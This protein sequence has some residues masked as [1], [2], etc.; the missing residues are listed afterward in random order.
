MVN[1][2]VDFV[3]FGTPKFGDNVMKFGPPA[4]QL[5]GGGFTF[6][7]KGIVIPCE[8]CHARTREAPSITKRAGWEVLSAHRQGGP[9]MRPPNPQSSTQNPQTRSP[10]PKPETR[11]LKRRIS[12]D[13]RGAGGFFGSTLPLRIQLPCYYH[14]LPHGDPAPQTLALKHQPRTLNSKA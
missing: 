4:S 14:H 6:D 1:Y 10:D 12:V 11:N 9:T 2:S 7:E 13:V 8:P 3:A 5:R